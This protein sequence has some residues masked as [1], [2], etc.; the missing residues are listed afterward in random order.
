[1]EY[2]YLTLVFCIP[3]VM[4]ILK[5]FFFKRIFKEMKFKDLIEYEKHSKKNYFSFFSKKNINDN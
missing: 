5:V 3:S 1:M 4:K 2:L